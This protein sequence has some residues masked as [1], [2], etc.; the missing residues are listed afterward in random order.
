MVIFGVRTDRGRGFAFLPV[1]DL[2]L[3]YFRGG[4][5]RAETVLPVTLHPW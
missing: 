1:F 3:L 2:N 5:E 4:V